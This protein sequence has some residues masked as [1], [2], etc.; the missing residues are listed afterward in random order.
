MERATSEG[1]AR[2]HLSVEGTG[3]WDRQ[4]MRIDFQNENL[5]ARVDGHVLACVPDLI[6]CL[7]TAGAAAQL[8]SLCFWHLAGAG[9]L[10]WHCMLV[11]THADACESQVE[12]LSMTLTWCTLTTSVALGQGCL[13]E[14]AQQAPCMLCTVHFWLGAPG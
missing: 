14:R 7:E 9:Q 12:D 11:S 2:G 6:C 4:A 3:P 1:F 5:I 13:Q 8:L 10:P